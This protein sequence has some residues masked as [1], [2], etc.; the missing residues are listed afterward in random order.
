M[1]I[2]TWGGIWEE[3]IK[4]QDEVGVIHGTNSNMTKVLK[5]LKS[6][7]KFISS[8][9][10]PL[11]PKNGKILDCGTGPMARYAIE[12]SKKGYDVT[13]VDISPTTIKF[14]KK[15]AKKAKKDVKFKEANLVD[16][17]GIKN[18][19]DL[20]FCIETFGH[21]PAHLSIE[22]LK[23][24]NRKLEIDG[25]CLVQFWIDKEKSF[26]N[27]FSEFLYFSALRIKEKFTNVFSVNVSRY[28]PEEIMDMC[29]ISGF[30]ILKEKNSCYLL[31]K[32]KEI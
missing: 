3:K 26:M 9:A 32:I 1:K 28:T 16:L 15:W 20:I 10:L 31:Q 18:K 30:K 21:I 17:S 2:K 24:F 8:W 27:L 7:M 22:V 12:F 6:D 4:A 25:L 29:K 11:V 19:F 5:Q 23:Q 14:A 13:G